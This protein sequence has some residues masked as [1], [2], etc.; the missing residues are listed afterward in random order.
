[1]RGYVSKKAVV[2]C[3]WGSDIREFG[4]KRVDKDHVTSVR[5]L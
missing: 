1:M 3:R 5:L 2:Q 4:I